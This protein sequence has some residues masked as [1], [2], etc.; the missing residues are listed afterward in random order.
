MGFH[1]FSA[2]AAKSEF[3]DIGIPQLNLGFCQCNGMAGLR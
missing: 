1:G 2:Y 3:C